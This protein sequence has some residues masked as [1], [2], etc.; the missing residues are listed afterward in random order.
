MSDELSVDDLVKPQPDDLMTNHAEQHSLITDLIVAKDK[1]QQEIEARVEG[2]N[3][4]AT[5]S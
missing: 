3:N 2:R 1:L 4:S 5:D